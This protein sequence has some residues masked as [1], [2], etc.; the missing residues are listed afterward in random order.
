MFYLSSRLNKDQHP[1]IPK[2][3][4]K[5]GDYNQQQDLSPLTL[6]EFTRS[7]LHALSNPQIMMML[8]PLRYYGLRMYLNVS[9]A[10][11]DA[12]TGEINSYFTNNNMMNGT[13]GNQDRPSIDITLLNTNTMDDREHWD[14]HFK[15]YAKEQGFKHET[16]AGALTAYNAMSG[17]TIYVKHDKPHNHV[18]LVCETRVNTPGMIL[19]LISILPNY[20]KDIIDMPDMFY[21]EVY[22]ALNRLEYDNVIKALLPWFSNHEQEKRQLIR[23]NN[24]NKV[25][26]MLSE[27]YLVRARND[28]KNTKE[29][30]Q[31]YEREITDLYARVLEYNKDLAYGAMDT[32]GIGEFINYAIKHPYIYSLRPGNNGYFE[33]AIKAHLRNYSVKHTTRFYE[34][35]GVD[36][37]A[38]GRWA[39]I[40]YAC[41]IAQT[42]QVQVYSV[43]ELG[44]N[45]PS[46]K[47]KAGGPLNQEL[48]TQCIW[49]PHHYSCQCFG[50]NS[51]IIKKA[52]SRKDYI[53]AIEQTI[54]SVE[55]FD[56]LDGSIPDWLNSKLEHHWET[57]CIWDKTNEKYITVKEV[58][59][60]ETNKA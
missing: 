8:Y 11:K 21:K 44:I 4:H 1:S 2:A 43:L 13:R 59:E 19:K 31:S 9:K 22:P 17:I 18:K 27:F 36:T 24:I 20:I 37:Y 54:Q 52:L 45:P 5:M 40:Y 55:S 28:L 25:G 33:V 50:N 32:T 49:Q 29:T 7:G 12:N 6:K 16:I 51:S 47:H 14:K 15:K 3:L 38:N 48:D 34:R 26:T 41:F 30:I 23:T 56:I 46:L 35:T 53:M 60:D 39:P 58:C 10:Y 42:H 57:P